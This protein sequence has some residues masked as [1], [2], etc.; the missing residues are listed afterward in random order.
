MPFTTGEGH[1]DE[2]EPGSTPF[3]DPDAIHAPVCHTIQHQIHDMARD[4]AIGDNRCTPQSEGVEPTRMKERLGPGRLHSPLLR[5][6]ISRKEWSGDVAD[7][8]LSSI[9][10]H[11]KY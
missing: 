6:G 8:D 9:D 2:G 3:P 5:R 1:N 10:C 11:S 7:S 4:G